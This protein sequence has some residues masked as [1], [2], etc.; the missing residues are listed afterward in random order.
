M[1]LLFSEGLRQFLVEYGY[2]EDPHA[3]PVRGAVNPSL[4]RTPPVGPYSLL[5]SR[6]TT[7]IAICG[8]AAPILERTVPSVGTSEQHAS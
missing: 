4:V 1:R 2:M 7:C 8:K 5:R 3:Y 6:S